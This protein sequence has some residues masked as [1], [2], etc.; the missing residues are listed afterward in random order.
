MQGGEPLSAEMASYARSVWELAA[1]QAMRS[2]KKLQAAGVHKSVTNRL[3]EPFMWHTVIVT[4]TDWENFWGLRCSALAQPEIRMVAEAMK[5]AFD[6]SHPLELDYGD[7]HAPYIQPDEDCLDADVRKVS[8]ARCARVSYL[9]HDGRRDISKDM[10]LY[11]RLV[12]SDPPH[13]SPLEHV[14]TPAR[15]DHEVQGNLRGWQQLRLLV[16]RDLA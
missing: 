13:A 5:A 8:A 6:A 15:P 7:W 16:M 2:A 11:D 1:D 9:T 3:L 14:A 4:A 12:S 10:E